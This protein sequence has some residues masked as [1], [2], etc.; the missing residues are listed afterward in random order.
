M[1]YDHKV[2]LPPAVVQAFP[3]SFFAKIVMD[4][5]GLLLKNLTL[6]YFHISQQTRIV[7]DLGPLE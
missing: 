4:M 5:V 1:L 7:N 3:F 6:H 2:C